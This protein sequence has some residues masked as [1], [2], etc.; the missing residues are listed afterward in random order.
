[1]ILYGRAMR[2]LAV[3]QFVRMIMTLAAITLMATT[4][5]E[6]PDTPDH[7]DSRGDEEPLSPSPSSQ[8]EKNT[9]NI[10]S[11]LESETHNTQNDS[12]VDISNTETVNYSYTA[13]F[14]QLQISGQNNELRRA[15]VVKIGNNNS[16]S[17]PQVGLNS[18]DIVFELLIEGI[19]TRFLAVYHTEIPKRISPVRSAR[20]SDFDLIRDLG[21]PYFVSSG[22][23]SKVLNEM[24]SAARK[25]I[26]IDGSASSSKA[27]YIRDKSRRSPYNLVF[28]Y[29][30]PEEDNENMDIDF[31]PQIFDNALTE[32]LPSIFKY[33]SNLDLNKTPFSTE[34]SDTD[35]GD[36]T[37]GL[38]IT[39]RQPAGVDVMHIWDETVQGWVRIQDGT[40]HV[41]ETDYGMAE[42]APTNVL[43]L[44]IDYKTSEADRGSPHAITYGEGEAWLLTQGE[45]I[46][47]FWKRTE[48]RIG[49]HL[50]DNEDTQLSLTPGKTWVLLTNR[51]GPHPIAQIRHIPGNEGWKLLNDAR[52][53]YTISQQ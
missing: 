24:K 40:L 21:N 45:I 6:S 1:M 26:M 37:V 35:S 12:T 30:P 50:T 20:S 28:A 15:V 2:P 11:E 3:L 51:R 5:E 52:I 46:Q 53:A 34:M 38:R 39:Y 27:Y 42:I 18:A 44:S 4:C 41:V 48:D 31:E 43:V 10:V 29:S 9:E 49:F 25:Q 22:G 36:N 19:R 7:S 13:P 14:T 23:N 8:I 16:S 17:R 47:A 32:A 33:S